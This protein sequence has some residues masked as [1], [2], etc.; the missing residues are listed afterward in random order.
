MKHFKDRK[1]SLFNYMCDILYNFYEKN[2]LE[3]MCALESLWAGNYKT[4]EDYVFLK[5]FSNVWERVEERET[6]RSIRDNK[7]ATD[8]E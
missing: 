1:F 7:S 4:I 6:I 2:E 3:H 5:R 8:E